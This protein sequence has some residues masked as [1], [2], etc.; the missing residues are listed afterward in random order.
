MDIH[1]P[2][3]SN[4]YIFSMNF[5][6]SLGRDL[7]QLDIRGKQ[8]YFNN[9]QQNVYEQTQGWHRLE[10]Y[11]HD[12]NI[13]LVWQHALRIRENSFGSSIFMFRLWKNVYN[14]DY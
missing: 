14:H 6:N 10:L 11:F 7:L 1:L 3:V 4:D 12:S 8:F 2:K 5:E 13:D 9:V